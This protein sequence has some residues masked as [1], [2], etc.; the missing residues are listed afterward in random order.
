M[1]FFQIY[2]GNSERGKGNVVH[3]RERWNVTVFT[4]CWRNVETKTEVPFDLNTV[5][6]R[7]KMEE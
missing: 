6:V 4:S 7:K 3:L 2:A 5:S 1:R